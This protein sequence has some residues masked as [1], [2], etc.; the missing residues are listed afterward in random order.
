MFT[1]FSVRHIRGARRSSSMAAPQLALQF[2]AEH[3]DEYL[4]LTITEFNDYFTIRSPSLFS[5]SNY[6]LTAQEGA[7]FSNKS[8]VTITY[9]Q[10]VICSR[11]CLDGTTHE[12]TIK[13]PSTLIRF[14]TKRS[15]FARFQKYL[16]PHSSF[17]YRFHPSTLQR[18]TCFK[19]AFI[20][21]VCML[22]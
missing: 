4:N 2:C 18:R 8:M 13:A 22:K 14:Q 15:C 9:E 7:V 10:N 5:L 11:T 21:L 3:F 6:S 12:Q 20:P 19:N 1:L 17:W 16:R